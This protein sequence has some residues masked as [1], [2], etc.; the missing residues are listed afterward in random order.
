MTYAYKVVRVE[1]DDYI[2]HNFIKSLSSRFRSRFIIRQSW[3]YAIIKLGIPKK[4]N[5]VTPEFQAAEFSYIKCRCDSARFIKV[6]KIFLKTISNVTCFSHMGDDIFYYDITNH[7]KKKYNIKELHYSSLF[8][9]FF[10]YY[11][12]K[13]V[14]PDKKIDLDSRKECGSGIH[15]VSSIID[16]ENFLKI[17]IL[18]NYYN[19][20][21][22]GETDGIF[23]ETGN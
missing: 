10:P 23:S 5:V 7:I 21:Q 18:K 17:N 9:H 20:V 13:Y 4:A 15:F 8:N 3:M 19:N 1:M 14:K 22:E 16:A 12:G 2:Y 6:E 11:F